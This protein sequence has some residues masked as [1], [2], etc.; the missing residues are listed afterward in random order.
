M[1]GGAVED[2]IPHLSNLLIPSRSHAKAQPFPYTFIK[3]SF[4]YWDNFSYRK[5]TKIVSIEYIWKCT[6]FLQF[7]LF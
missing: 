7:P 5:V 6:S 4:L 1:K 2:Q 3:I